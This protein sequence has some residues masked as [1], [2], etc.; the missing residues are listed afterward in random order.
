MP[1]YN[2]ERI[3]ANGVELKRMQGVSISFESQH[4]MPN[5]AGGNKTY[6]TNV[7]ELLSAALSLNYVAV[8]GFNESAMGINGNFIGQL[9]SGLDIKNYQIQVSGGG[10]INATG[11]A[12]VSYTNSCSVGD[13]A[14]ADA[15]F[16]VF[17]LSFTTGTPITG[18]SPT[19]A[20]PAIL[21]GHI[22][23]SVTG[24]FGITNFSLEE[25]NLS[26]S[27]NRDNVKYVGDKTPSIKR[28]GFPVE[29]EV[30]VRG[31]VEGFSVSNIADFFTSKTGYGLS[32]TFKNKSGVNTSGGFSLTNAYLVSQDVSN[33]ALGRTMVDMT[34]RSSLGLVDS[35]DAPMGVLM[36]GI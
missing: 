17:D 11:A 33:E 26:V 32:V 28:V 29:A 9:V 36:L 16:E 31:Y 34:F 25:Y 10:T 6:S 27:V 2:T 8:E 23:L 21:A 13:Y 19:G 7:Q 35:K 5:H 22:N 30:S 3:V 20:I 12:L 15:T 18:A 14:K 1:F 24:G 4:G